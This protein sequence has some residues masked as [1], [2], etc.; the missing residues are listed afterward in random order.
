MCER[1]QRD[2]ESLPVEFDSRYNAYINVPVNV[3]LGNGEVLE[4]ISLGTTEQ[5]ELR[6]LVEEEERIFNSAEISL[7]KGAEC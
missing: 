3:L 7:R 6:V 2:Y 4:G 1:Y 5:G